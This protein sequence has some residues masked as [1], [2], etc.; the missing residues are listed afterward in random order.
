MPEI[1]Q[2]VRKILTDEFK[3]PFVRRKLT[4]IKASTGACYTHEFD[5]VSEDQ[6]IVAEVKGYGFTTEAAYTTTQQWRILGDCFRLEKVAA[7]KKLMI[8]T[9]KEIHR[10]FEK[11]FGGLLEPEVEIRFMPEA[12]D[13]PSRKATKA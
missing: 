7:Q 9:D 6:A 13:Q 12:L 1:E 3:L 8:L 10:R 5:C 4:I 11:D 2:N